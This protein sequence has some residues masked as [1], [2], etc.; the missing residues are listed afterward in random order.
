MC[1]YVCMYLKIYLLLNFIRIILESENVQT[2]AARNIL[3]QYPNTIIELQMHSE[4]PVIVALSID[5]T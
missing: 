2:R 4:P 3:R 1:I 5:H